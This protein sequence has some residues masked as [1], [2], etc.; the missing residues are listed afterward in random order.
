[1]NRPKEGQ[2]RNGVMMKMRHQQVDRLI[3]WPV[4]PAPRIDGP[5][6]NIDD[7]AALGQAYLDAG[8]VA[9]Y[10]SMSGPG[11]GHEPRTPQSVSSG[12]PAGPE[13]GTSD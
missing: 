9:P 1:M 2:L 8:R 5:R 4:R 6:Y 11:T 10:R 13:A 3:F 12:A 7:I